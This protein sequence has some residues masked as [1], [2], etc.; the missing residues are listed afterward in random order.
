MPASTPSAPRKAGTERKGPAAAHERPGVWGQCLLAWL[1]PGAGHFRAGQITKAV[2]FFAVLV[3][4]FG[5]GLA[6][7][8]RLFPFGTSE[9]LVFLAA[10]AEWMLLVPRLLAS[11]GGLGRGDVVAITYEYGNTFLIVA[12]LLNALIVLDV[13]DLATGRKQS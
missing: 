12:G 9:P 7:G 4:M 11:L 2:V 6:F 8:G 1:L 10:V 5:L 13:Y 3:T